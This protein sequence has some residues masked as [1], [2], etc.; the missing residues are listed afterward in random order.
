MNHFRPHIE[1]DLIGVVLAGERRPSCEKMTHIPNRKVFYVRFIKP[2]G[3]EV[4]S[5]SIALLECNC[6]VRNH[7]EFY[8]HFE[9]TNLGY[10]ITFMPYSWR[11]FLCIAGNLKA[12]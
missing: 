5:D 12:Y 1:K 9:L 4:V 11:I 3:E 7:N 8:L 10:R 2:E 6:K